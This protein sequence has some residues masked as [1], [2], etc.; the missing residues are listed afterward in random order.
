MR[1]K[2]GDW[3]GYILWLITE[4][5]HMFWMYTLEWLSCRKIHWSSVFAPKASYFLSKWP[6]TSKNPWCP[7]YSHDFQFLHRTL[8]FDHGGI[9][10]L[11]TSRH[12]ADP[13][14]WKV[15]IWSHHSIKHSFRSPPVYPNEFEHVQ[16]SLTGRTCIVFFWYSVFKCL[17][18]FHW[19]I[20]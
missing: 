18:S 10:L 1:I 20:L 13:W 7:S 8:K 5:M 17:S 14:V 16:V 6:D 19:V 15:P 12:T 4:P 2:P 3:T 11:W 9:F